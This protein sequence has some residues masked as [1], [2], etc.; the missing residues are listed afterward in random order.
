MT[1][2]F[3][4]LLEAIVTNP[5]ESVGTLPLLT[6]KERHQ[7]L[8]E[9]NNTDTT[10]SE[11]KCIHQLFEEQAKRTPDAVAVVCSGQQLTYNE[12]N[13]RAN[14]LAHYLRKL[15]IKADTLVGISLERSLEMIVG[16]LGILKAGG[17]YVPLDPDYPSERLQFAIA[18]A[19]LSFLLTQEGLIDKLPEHQ[20]RL[21]LLEQIRGRN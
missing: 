11:H 14:Q 10:Y 17:A 13:C 4:T 9:W 3:Q 8:V 18:D 6:K 19:Q 21:I 2:H 15:G 12:L 7:L 16:L 20:A 1:G 5:Q